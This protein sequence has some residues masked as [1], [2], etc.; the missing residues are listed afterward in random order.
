MQR[1]TEMVDDVSK[2]L[3]LVDSSQ[4][5]YYKKYPELFDQSVIGNLVILTCGHAGVPNPVEAILFEKHLKKAGFMYLHPKKLIV[6][7]QEK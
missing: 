6:P 7:K 2:Y 3:E 4:L 1:V 5:N